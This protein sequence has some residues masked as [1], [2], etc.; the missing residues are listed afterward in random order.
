[1]KWAAT[2]LAAAGAAAAVLLL[3][4]RGET[5][6]SPGTPPAASPPPADKPVK[7]FN[8]LMEEN[9]RELD[10]L[11]DAVQKHPGDAAVKPRLGRIRAQAEAARKIRPLPLAAENDELDEYFASF[12]SHL[13]NLEQASWDA[14]TAPKLLRQLQFR[15]KTCHE[16]WQN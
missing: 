16:R 3:F 9:Q 6:P 7:L 5:A 1:M 12:L 8:S 14:P 15:C 13:G 11:K 2:L 10:A 4:L